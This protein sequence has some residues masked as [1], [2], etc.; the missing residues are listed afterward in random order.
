MKRY[1]NIAL[2]C[3]M[4]LSVS[5]QDLGKVQEKFFPQPEN[6]NLNTPLAGKRTGYTSY[7]EMK[8]FLSQI[9]KNNPELISLES[10]G[11]TQKGRDI[12][13][14]KI[15]GGK[16]DEEKM[17]VLYFGRIH[18]DEPGGTEGLL[19]FIERMTADDSLRYL[20]DKMDFYIVPM[21]NADGG[22]RMIRQTANGIDLNR[23]QVRMESPEAVA[24]R[25]MINRIEPHV[26]I[27]FHEYQPLKSAYS[28]VSEEI[29][30]VPW[31]VMFLTSG[32]PNVPNGVRHKIESLFLPNAKMD[33]IE[34]DFSSHTYYTP[35]KTSQGVTMNMG[36]SSPR[37]TSNALS[38]SNT[39]SILIEGR[40]IGL[41]RK[42]ISRR[43]KSVYVLAG[44]FANT[45]YQNK[46]ELLQTL[47][48]S[49]T[50]RKPVA[51]DFSSKKHE[52]EPLQFINQ[53]KNRI[54]IVPLRVTDAMNATVEKARELPEQYLILPGETEARKALDNMGI[55]YEIMPE[56]RTM[57][58]ESYLI[59]STEN[60]SQSFKTFTP[61]R[62]KTQIRTKE[63]T[64][65]E[66]TI[67]ID[68]HQDK[69]RLLSLML[70]PE[71]SNGFVNY[72]LI[73][74]IEGKELPV[75]RVMSK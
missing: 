21:V 73:E 28:M 47:A 63:V 9:E 39:Y 59:K 8:R 32:N 29:L 66:G 55:G 54:D 46:E 6:L 56:T 20:L 34:N 74:A 5:A 16:Q 37:S 23:D 50:D 48:L 52:S 75:Y 44:S 27:D 30:T 58:V 14:V 40:G 24:L 31:D 26:T 35:K 7:K 41:S 2:A 62:V 18:G 69:V 71:S 43:L 42:T 67:V 19:H 10:I 51:I 15:A 38:L 65:P 13:M 12:L 64:F 60:E 49:K 25:T 22:E 3:M 4:S 53:L 33:L 11:K 61:V 57:K 17:R 1:I 70:E 72:R 68:T 36:G 45:C